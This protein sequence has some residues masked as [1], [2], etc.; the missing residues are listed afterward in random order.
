[1]YIKRIEL[2]NIRGFKHLDFNLDRGN[3]EYAGWTVITGD[4]GSGKSSL[5]KAI[6]VCLVGKDTARALQPSFVGWTRSGVGDEEFSITL[7]I[8]RTQGDDEFV[9]QGKTTTRDFKAKVQIRASG[10]EPSLET[11]NPPGVHATYKTPDR[12]VWSS[13]AWGWFSCGYGPFRRVFGASPE[14]TQQMVSSST[15][16]YATMFNEAASLTEADRWIRDLNYKALENRTNEKDHLEKVLAI[17]KDDLIPSDM[18]IERIDSDGLWLRDR[19]RT[20]LSWKDM[21]DGYRAALALLVDILRHMII[22]YGS[23]DLFA[24]DAGGHIV[25]NRSGVV[26]IDEIDAHLH[27]EWQRKIGFWLKNHFPKIQFLVTT[28]SPIICQAADRNGIFKLPDPGSDQEP[29]A[30]RE[31]EYQ[32][33]IA[34]RP[35]TILLTSAF[36][37]ENTRSE[38]A[39]KS[40]QGYSRLKAMERAGVKLGPDQKEELKQLALFAEIDEEL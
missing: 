5:L 20:L 25:V 37:L 27:P 34:A 6:A 35:D 36:G 3:G 7:D 17:L 8:V 9:D 24:Q 11:T 28:H 21:S 1:M 18:A 31:E 33:I 10:K 15:T 30:V 2:R 26:L 13:E 4:N 19:N 14:A 16:R 23:D 22:A 40:R 12:S 32:K 39:I 29:F 38:R